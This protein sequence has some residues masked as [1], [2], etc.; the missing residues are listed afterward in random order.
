MLLV[1]AN[2]LDLVYTYFGLSRG[3]FAEGNPM[4]RPLLYTAW[5]LTLKILALAGLALGIA[6]LARTSLPR[7]QAVLQT[8]KLTTAIYAILLALHVVNLLTSIGWVAAHV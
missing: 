8:L 7:Q 4:W 2:E 6:A 5:P 3:A 1:I